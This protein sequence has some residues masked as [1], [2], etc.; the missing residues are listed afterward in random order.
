M[1]TDETLKPANNK[2][3]K[4][5]KKKANLADADDF[6]NFEDGPDDAESNKTPTAPAEN[7]NLLRKIKLRCHA[8]LSNEDA[9]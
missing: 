7:G 1:F 4:K 8:V 3:D 5:G 9:R 6:Y 2:K